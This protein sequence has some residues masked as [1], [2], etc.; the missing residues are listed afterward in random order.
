[1]VGGTLC[2]CSGEYKKSSTQSSSAGWRGVLSRSARSS[3]LTCSCGMRASM[4]SGRKL[5]GGCWTEHQSCV[6]INH[7]TAM[8]DLG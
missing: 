3:L 4:A 8:S 6:D 1:M 7:G 2:S 5:R